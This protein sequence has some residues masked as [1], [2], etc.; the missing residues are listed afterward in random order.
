VLPQSRRHAYIA[1]LLASHLVVAINKMDLGF[2]EDVYSR[3][4]GLCTFAAAKWG[5]TYIPI[6]ALTATTW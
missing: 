4:R 6:S 5:I 1:A 2:R 3:F